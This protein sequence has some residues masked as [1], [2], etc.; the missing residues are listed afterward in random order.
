MKSKLLNLWVV[1][2]PE[3]KTRIRFQAQ[4]RQRR[5]GRTAQSLL[6]ILIL[7]TACSNSNLAKGPVPDADPAK[8]APAIELSAIADNS[9][10]SLAG[11]KG[12]VVLVDFW[13]TWCGPCRMELP[14]FVQLQEDY[15]GKGF[16]MLGVSVDQYSR[17]GIA[18]FL[19]INQ[20]NYPVVLDEDQDVAKRYGGINAIPYTVLI[21]KKGIIRQTY[22]GYTEPEVFQKAVQQLLNET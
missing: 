7:C 9:P 8:V 19:R 16:T 18:A 4:F 5:T 21:D 3:L 13:A 6:L 2:V 20:I 12:K 17:D 11:L 1:D 15:Q 22:V 14:H 10:V